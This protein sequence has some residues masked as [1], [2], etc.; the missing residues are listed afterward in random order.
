MEPEIQRPLL[1]PGASMLFLAALLTAALA[2]LCPLVV[3]WVLGFFAAGDP[4]KELLIATAGAIF[5]NLLTTVHCF[6]AYRTVAVAR[7]LVDELEQIRR[8]SEPRRGASG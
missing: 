3:A 2:I 7:S 5:V 8:A 6:L 1:V 4:E